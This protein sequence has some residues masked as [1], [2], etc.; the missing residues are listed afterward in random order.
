MTWPAVDDLAR[1]YLLLALSVGELQAGII[2]SYYGPPELRA[3]A[4]ARGAAPAELVADAS[5]LRE[6]V[7]RERDPQRARWLDVQLVAL[8]TLARRLGG[9]QMS[10]RDEV[11]RC[12]DARPEPTPAGTYARVR[13]R[14]DELLLP[15]TDLHARLEARNARLTVPADKVGEICEWLVAELRR[16]CLEVFP[17]PAGEDLSLHM[18]S[19]QPWSAYNWYDG[20][21]RS[22]IEINTDLP[23]RAPELIGL[24]THEAFP[25]H[26]LE[27]AWKETRLANELGRGEASAQ[28]VNTPEAYISEGLAEIGGQYVAGRE[29]WQELLTGICGRAGIALGAGDAER[30]WQTSRTLHELRGSS[31]DAVLLLHE[32]GRSRDEVVQFLHDDGLQ[33]RERAE[34]SLEFISHPLWRTYVFCYAGGERLLGAWCAAAG[35]IDAQRQRFVRL[36]TEQLTPSGIAAE[37]A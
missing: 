12:F 5:A 24:M 23:S 26:H 32:G 11:E 30:E 1:D 8:E 15:G 20:R 33:T 4:A 3:Q 19:G 22:R 29:R 16:F 25:G 6:R 17:A 7:A 28:L 35:G 13:L 27:H 31:G 34:K 9:E 37:A 21:L 14:L 2:D 18:V 10:Y 36:L